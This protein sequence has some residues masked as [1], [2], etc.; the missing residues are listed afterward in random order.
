MP[1]TLQ[2]KLFW[3]VILPQFPFYEFALKKVQSPSKAEGSA[4]NIASNLLVPWIP[5]R[6]SP[7]GHTILRMSTVT[8]DD[9]ATPWGSSFCRDEGLTD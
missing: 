5:G 3:R 2:A 9:E 1:I 7:T 4:M 8:C 6:A